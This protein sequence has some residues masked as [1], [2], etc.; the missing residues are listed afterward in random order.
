MLIETK[1]LH[2]CKVH[3]TDGEIGTIDEVL[4][5]DNT[6]IVRY[7]IVA[8]GP[9]L[10]QRKVLIVPAKVKEID[11]ATRTLNIDLTRDQVENSPGVDTDKPVSRQW[12]TDYYNYYA[13]PYY[14]GGN[15]GWGQTWGTRPPM[16]LMPFETPQLQQHEAEVLHA[17]DDPHLRSSKALVGYKISAKDGQVGH[18]RGFIVDDLT[19]EIQYL[20]VDTGDWWPGKKV[21]LPLSWINSINWPNN[22]VPIEAT[23]LEVQNTP[24]WDTEET[25]TSE[26][27]ANLHGYYTSHPHSAPVAATALK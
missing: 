15:T 20:G 4:F 27:Q 2:G 22:T 8:A 18:V 21:L 19:W 3:A 7:L 17:H 16:G 5:E 14:W 1:T 11:W 26:F 12:E 25:I 10:F 13:L 6:W 9:W 23:R 24:E